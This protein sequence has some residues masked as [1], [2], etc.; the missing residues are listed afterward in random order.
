MP[1]RPVDGEEHLPVG[2]TRKSVEP[3][4]GEFQVV[5]YRNGIDERV[6]ENAILLASI[7]RHV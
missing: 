4:G 5:L 1:F 3:T 6:A 2:P 7:E